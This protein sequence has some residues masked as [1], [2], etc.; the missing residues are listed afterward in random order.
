MGLNFYAIGAYDGLAGYMVEPV[1]VVSLVAVMED[2]GLLA[3]H[4]L[5]IEDTGC[6]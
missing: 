6:D 2:F 5:A 3:L 1:C 4:P